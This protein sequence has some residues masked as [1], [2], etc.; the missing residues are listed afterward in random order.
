[1]SKS[2]DPVVIVWPMYQFEKDYQTF[3]KIGEGHYG[4][5][6]SARRKEASSKKKTRPE[7]QTKKKK[8]V[9]QQEGFFISY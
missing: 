1:M 4:K 8:E 2:T 6:Y 3:E 5:V 9:Q 7:E